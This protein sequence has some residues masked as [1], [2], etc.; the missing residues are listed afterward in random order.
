MDVFDEIEG[1]EPADPTVLEDFKREMTE[2]VIPEVVEVMR[3]R[4]RYAEEA[5]RR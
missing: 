1:L 5:R 4:A 2:R 3:E